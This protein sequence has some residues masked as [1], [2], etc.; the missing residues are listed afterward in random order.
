MQRKQ[1]MIIKVVATMTAATGLFELCRYGLHSYWITFTHFSDTLD[2]VE[3]FGF[4][5]GIVIMLIPLLKLAAAIGLFLPKRWGWLLAL[6]ILGLNFLGGIQAAIRMC[7]YSFNPP[8]LAPPPMD[9]NVTVQVISM[10]P[11]YIIAIISLISMIILL[12]KP[13]KKKFSK[14]PVSNSADSFA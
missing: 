2:L 14:V 4:A 10:W 12:Q 6:I 9:P 8:V 1:K 5:L 7:I 11:M 13:I 3:P